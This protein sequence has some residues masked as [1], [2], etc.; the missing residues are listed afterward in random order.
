LLS[1][2]DAPAHGYHRS[3]QNPNYHNLAPRL[4]FSYQINPKTV[5][6]AAG[7]IFYGRD[8]NVPVADRPTNNPPFF[9]QTAYTSDSTGNTPPPIFLDQGFPSNAINPATVLTPA[10]NSFVKNSP[11]PYVQQWNLNLQRDIGF[12]FVGQLTYVG[13]SSHH[14]YYPNQIDQPTPGA[15][16][17]QARRPLPQYSAVRQYA[18]VISSN[19][20]S[21]QAQAERRFKNGFS[22]LAA[23]TYGH[24]IDNGP[25]Q[26]DTASTPQNALNLAAERGSSTFDIRHRLV[27]SS[28]Y[29]LPFG[30]G[31]FFLANSRVGNAIAGGWLLTGIFSA[32]TGLPFTPVEA[33]DGSNTGTTQ[34]PNRI[35]NGNL[36]SGQ[37]SVNKWFDVTAFPTP[38]GFAFG[39]SGRDILSGPGFHNVDLSLAR[40]IALVL[41]MSLEVRAEA[42]NLF[43]TPQY[44][45]PN[46]TLNQATTATIS[47]VV[48]PQRELQFAARLRF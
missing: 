41:H 37:R 16:A 33:T 26:V 32:Q 1:A 25:S 46:A 7:G 21:L 31:K 35:A 11:T 30:K 13:S 15:G 47:T 22:L 34:H 3:F 20:N 45:L 28:V 19:Y 42:F 40:S 18:P 24:S 17:V 27:V 44:G 9:I 14:L 5:V 36:P 12:G 39:N 48:N 23:Y 29:E 2:T 8:E 6:R 38:T 10:T 43:N 4:G